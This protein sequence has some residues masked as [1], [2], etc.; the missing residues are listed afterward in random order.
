MGAIKDPTKGTQ[1]NLKKFARWFK[2]QGVNL[3][4]VNGD[5][6]LDEFDLE[7]VLAAIGAIYKVPILVHSGNSESRTSFNRMV[8]EAQKKYPLLINGNFVR[9]ID[10]GEFSLF[11]LPGYHDKRFFGTRSACA[12][13]KRHTNALV[14]EIA[15]AKGRTAVLIAHGPPK[16][17][18]AVALDKIIQGKHVGDPMITALMKAAKI[19]Y[20]IF[21]HIL[22]AGGTLASRSGRAVAQEGKA[23]KSLMVNVGSACNFPLNLLGKKESRGMAA[24][25]TLSK[26]TGEATFKRID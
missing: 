20:G 22:E 10:W 15:K 7:E 9:R 23:Y 3:V 5:L 11:T 21:G 17:K 4:V 1:K 14:T 24:V 19:R 12:Y 8:T 6:A 26:K 13:D 16:L 25:V 2:K 18:G